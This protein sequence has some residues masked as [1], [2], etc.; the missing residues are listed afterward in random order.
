[1]E[2]SFDIALCAGLRD[3]WPR[4]P[5]QMQMSCLGLLERTMA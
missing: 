4:K 2:I 5:L 3:K 1:M